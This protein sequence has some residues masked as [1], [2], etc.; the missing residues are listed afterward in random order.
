MLTPRPELTDCSTA[1]GTVLGILGGTFDP[2]HLGHRALADAALASGA[3]SRIRW[4]PAGQPPHRSGPAASA[5]HRLAMVRLMI[6]DQPAF[7]IDDSEVAAA[8]RGEPSY[9]VHTLERLRLKLGA[10]QPLALILGADAFLGL[11]SWHRW[12]DIP[13]LTHLL[14][15]HRPGSSL[16]PAELPEPLRRLWDAARTEH[17]ARLAELPAGR[18][19]HFPMSPIDLSATALRRHLSGP[20]NGLDGLLPPALVRYIR[21][22][23]LYT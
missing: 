19:Y 10:D 8:Q 20:D 12:T 21:Q 16:D 7:E 18:I 1:S 13:R 11:P 2:V 9:T 6:A 3:V 15:T 17:P 5:E 4:I 23:N 22:Q 14:V